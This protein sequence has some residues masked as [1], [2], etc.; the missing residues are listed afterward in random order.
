M[1]LPQLRLSLDA[2]FPLRA[3]VPMEHVVVSHGHTDHLAG[4]LPWAAQRQLQNL[5]PARVYSPPALAPDLQRLLDLGAAMEQGKPY[6]V[7]VEPVSPGEQVILRP[8]MVLRFFPTTHWTPTLGVGLFW[9]KRQLK[10]ELAGLGGEEIRQLRESGLEVVETVEVPL[11]AYLADSGPEVLYREHWLA[12]VEVLVVECTFL[13]PQDRERAKR[14]GHMHL[15]DLR[16]FLPHSHNRHWVL[17]HLSRRH[18]L[19]PATK[20]IRQVLAREG[21]P[22]LHLLNVEWP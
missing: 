11:L 7:K 3:F 15:D 4:L 17:M 12:Q 6:P 14:F 9:R 19:G 20:T 2:G 13:R 16:Q 22:H 5:G 21:G 8:D 18:R 1:L 10:P